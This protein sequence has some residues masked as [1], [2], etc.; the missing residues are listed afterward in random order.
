MISRYYN[1]QG[2]T[3][4]CLAELAERAG[5]EHAVDVF[6]HEILDG[7]DAPVRFVGVPMRLRP[8]WA[9]GPTFERAVKERL[10]GRAYDVVHAHEGANVGADIYTA[11]SCYA[12]WLRQRRAEAGVRGLA[13]HVYP[14]HVIR[15][16]LIRR[17]M[18][19]RSSLIIA[20]SGRVRDELI[21]ELAV[22]PQR[23]A[24]VHNG[25][26]TDDFRPP[27]T[28][29]EAFAQLEEPHLRDRAGA[30]VLLFVA[31][32]FRKR[33][34]ERLI[35]ALAQLEDARVEVWVI[36]RDDPA[37]F[38][39][40]AAQLGVADRLR[41]L[42]H[43]AVV[44]PYFQAADALVLPTEYEAF[45]LVILEAMACGRPVLTSRRAGAA[46]LV[47]DGREGLLLDDPHDVEELVCGLRGLVGDD[48]RRRTMGAAARRVAERHSWDAVW[49]RT[50]DIYERVAAAKHAGLQ[51]WQEAA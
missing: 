48:A 42:G 31:Y 25:T 12:A 30:L 46:E 29:E 19:E 11:H 17:G 4:R 41:F 3:S 18:R 28:R 49:R 38:R 1:R 24:V 34:L 20:V 45:G 33:G 36:G 22:D 23:I 40:L 47:T 26:D 6:A 14:P 9:Q 21:E 13:S 39:R 35:R 7:E 8:L 51:A 10:D 15:L 32:E 16:G 44:R 2:G 37:P 43:R 27:R 5:R 50:A